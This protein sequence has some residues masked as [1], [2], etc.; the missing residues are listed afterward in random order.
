MVS[1]RLDPPLE[2]AAFVR[3]V[4]GGWHD[5]TWGSGRD[6]QEVLACGF[7]AEFQ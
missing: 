4:S 1:G 3:E 5:L 2:S 6:R 7:H